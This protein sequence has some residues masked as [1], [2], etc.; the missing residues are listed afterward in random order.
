MASFWPFSVG[1]LSGQAQVSAD[2]GGGFLG[3]MLSI[4]S[5]ACLLRCV[6][7]L[8]EA[9]A[10]QESQNIKFSVRDICG[11]ISEFLR[12]LVVNSPISHQDDS[13]EM[14]CHHD[15]LNNS[16][17][18]MVLFEGFAEGG[19]LHIS[20]SGWVAWPSHT[21]WSRWRRWGIVKSYQKGKEKRDA[22]F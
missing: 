12:H 16:T 5:D 10:F 22:L 3:N 20:L 15:K 2:S 11:K 18:S 6:T 9:L 4:S 17:R 7:C 21:V 13:N 8:S 19:I 14:N 1:G